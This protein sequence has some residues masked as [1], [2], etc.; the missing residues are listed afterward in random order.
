MTRFFSKR[1]LSLEYFCLRM[2]DPR[3]NRPMR[4]LWLTRG[5]ISLLPSAYERYGVGERTL[6]LSASSTSIPAQAAIFVI[7]DLV[8]AGLR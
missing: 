1:K 7:A 2:Q 4:L 8:M 5:K 3:F 6:T